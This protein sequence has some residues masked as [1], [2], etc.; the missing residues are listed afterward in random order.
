MRYIL[1]IL[2]CILFLPAFVLADG[3]TLILL[4]R[5]T[6][7]Y[8]IYSVSAYNKNAFVADADWGIRVINYSDPYNPYTL[9]RYTEPALDIEI[10]DSLAYYV[11]FDVSNVGALYIRDILNPLESEIVGSA[12]LFRGFRLHLFEN[13]VLA[14]FKSPWEY[15]YL[16]ILDISDPTNPETLS[17]WITVPPYS[18]A[19]WGDVWKRSNY[20]YWIDREYYPDAGKIAVFDITDPTEPIPI[21]VDTCLQ[22]TAHAIWIKNNYAYVALGK[23]YEVDYGG[24][25]VL[26]ISDPYSIDSIGFF[27]IPG[28]SAINVCIKGKYAY[29]SVQEGGIYVLDITNPI[30]PTLVTYYDSPGISKDVFV[31]EPYVLVADYTSLLVFEASFLSN[32]PGDANNDKQVNISD[33]VYLIDYLFKSGLEPTNSDLA[34]VNADCKIDL[35]DVVHLINY[36]YKNGPAPQMGCVE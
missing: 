24:L 23:T 22:S 21:V 9:T 2:V 34:D 12:P 33:V 1:A 28:K 7:M 17:T 19:H 26:D 4:G 29:V 35:G 31:D 10:R 8:H 36:L 27:E 18:T 16:N 11:G 20:I 25:M 13:L 32:V 5:S 30:N 6:E 14:M 3:D 15:V